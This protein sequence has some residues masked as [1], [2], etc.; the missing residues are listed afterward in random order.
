MLLRTSSEF[1]LFA[2]DERDISYEVGQKKHAQ[3]YG[4]LFQAHIKAES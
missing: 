3:K 2:D 4:Y 1:F